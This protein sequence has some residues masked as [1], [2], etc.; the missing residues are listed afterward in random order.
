VAASHEPE[1][2]ALVWEPP[3]EPWQYRVLDLLPPGVDLAQLEQAR[4][5]TPTQRVEAAMRLA[6]IAEAIWR[7][8]AKRDEAP[9]R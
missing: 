7:A 9:P 6:E 3:D 5:L 2:A 4:K 8:R 1:Y